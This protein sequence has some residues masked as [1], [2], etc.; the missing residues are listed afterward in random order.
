MVAEANV[1]AHGLWYGKKG[2]PLLPGEE[3]FAKAIL[4]RNLANVENFKNHPSVI[5]WSLGNEAGE[6][7]SLIGAVAA[8]KALDPSRP[9]HYRDFGRKNGVGKDNPADFDSQTY[10]RLNNLEKIAVDPAL[11]K[12]FYM[13]EFAHAMFNSMGALG[14]YNDQI[15]AQPAL[16]GG[17]IWEFQDQGLWNRRDPQH[18][19]LAYGGGFGDFPND[20]YFIHK[21][22][23]AFDRSPKPHY[24]EMKRVFQWIDIELA[25]AGPATLTIKNKYQFIDLSCLDAAWTLCEDGQPIQNGKLPLPALAP[26]SQA[27]IPMPGNVEAPKPGAEYFLNLSFTLKQDERWAKKGFEVA[28]AQFKLPVGRP[29]AVADLAAMKLVELKQD[30]QTATIVGD[31]FKVVFD[32]A[33]GTISRLERD[34]VNLLA[35]DGGPR[36]HLW[37]TPHRNDDM[38]AFDGWSKYGLD[39]LKTTVTAFQAE[40][41]APATVRVTATLQLEGKQGFAATQAVACT[42]FGDGSIAVDNAVRFAGPKIALARLGVRLLLDKQLDHFDFFGRGPMENYAD[43]KR[44]ADVGLYGV[45][46][47]RQYEYEKTMERGNHEDVRWAALTGAGLPGLFAQADGALLQA[48]ALPHADEQM[49]PVE[50]KIDLPPSTATVV[51]LAAKT[52]GVGSASCGPQPADS[53]RVMSEPA[54]FSY[55]LRL[56]PKGTK[57]SAELARMRLP[58]RPPLE[59]QKPKPDQAK[60]ATPAKE[61]K[62]ANE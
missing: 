33:S 28:T 60:P 22:V 3:H 40:Q 23:V 56:L 14:E 44:G 12:P 5:I 32:K 53:C 25:K 55:I 37:R 18:P 54:A 11:T 1:E 52:L 7:A 2:D 41:T 19:I 9:V 24:Q 20:K 17:A 38:W 50:Y 58:A 39:K 31:G 27:T 34:G 26:L 42:V 45:E 51:I 15:D 10:T 49:L 46:V 59:M 8:I 43:R 47:N 21:G 61:F 36:L 13:N 30:G 4:D 16:L 62:G 35:A 29:A 48:A 57:P 6:G